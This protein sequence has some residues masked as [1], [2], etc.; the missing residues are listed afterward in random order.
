MPHEPME[1]L[2]AGQTEDSEVRDELLADVPQTGQ[3]LEPERVSRRAWVGRFLGPILA[4]VIFVILPTGEGG[5]SQ[6]DVPRSRS[7]P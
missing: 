2:M 4:I 7:A 1:Q 6:A 5:L 3:R